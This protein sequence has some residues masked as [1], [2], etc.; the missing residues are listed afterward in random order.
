[1]KKIVWKGL[2]LSGTYQRNRRNRLLLL[3]RLYPMAFRISSDCRVTVGSRTRRHLL[4]DALETGAPS[5]RHGPDTC[6]P[7]EALN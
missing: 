6:R 5:V 1:M 3:R 2:R 4:I 7:E